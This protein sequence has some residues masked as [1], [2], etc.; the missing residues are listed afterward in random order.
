MRKLISSEKTFRPHSN[1][2]MFLTNQPEKGRTIPVTRKSVT[3]F[4]L[5]VHHFPIHKLN[6]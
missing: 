2:S 1:R 6:L 3:F 4:Q 5:Y